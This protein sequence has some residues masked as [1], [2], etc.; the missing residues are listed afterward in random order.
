MFEIS[1][2]KTPLIG[3][4]S[5]SIAPG[6]CVALRGASGAGK[7]LLLRA[8]ADLDPNEGDALL[9]QQSRNRMPAPQWRRLVALI[10]AE[11]GWWTDNVADH[12][13]PGPETTALLEAIGLPESL[14]WKI[15][16]LS[17]GEKQRLALARALL[18][19]PKVLLLD[20]PTSALDEQATARVEDIIREQMDL[21]VTVLLVTHDQTQ[22]R[23]IGGRHFLMEDGRLSEVPE[24]AA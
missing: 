2:L 5:L 1:D 21:G 22:A 14:G 17:T 20:E 7:S 11:S 10:P 13:K 16:R 18:N 23:R 3:P 8:V 15:N 12:F 9:D 6:E 19:K 4:V 24:T